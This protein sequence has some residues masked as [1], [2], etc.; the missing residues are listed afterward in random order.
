MKNEQPNLASNAER[1]RNG[2]RGYTLIEFVV[3]AIILMTIAGMA[4]IQLRPTWQDQQANAAMD[5]VKSALRQARETAVGQRRTIVVKFVAAGTAPCT[6]GSNINNCI[7]LYQMVVSGTPPTATQAANP[8]L[9]LPLQANVKLGTFSGETDTP[10]G[11]SGCGF[12]IPSSGGIEFGGISGG[13]ASGMA[14]Q[15][16]GTFTDGTG[17]P[18][19]GTVFLVVN[20]I[21]NSG[22]AVTI[23]GNTGRIRAWKNNTSGWFQ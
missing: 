8:Y 23:L 14:F 16:D 12:G 19:N 17:V 5:Q 9:T 6:A 21:N 18:I 20:S 1:P 3:A 4:I 11:C 15:S 2:E 10:D 13:P 7:A 22:R